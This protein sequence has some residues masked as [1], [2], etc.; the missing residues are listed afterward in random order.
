M[1]S[2]NGFKEV[3]LES[4]KRGM[5]CSFWNNTD[6]DDEEDDDGWCVGHYVCKTF[7]GR[8]IGYIKSIDKNEVFDNCNG[9][10]LINKKVK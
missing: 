4:Y 8:Y 9:M 1:E 10:K 6:P 2:L 3:E 5:L 7:D